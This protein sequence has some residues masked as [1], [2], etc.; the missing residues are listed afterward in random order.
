MDLTEE[1]LL[2]GITCSHCP[3]TRPAHESAFGVRVDPC[4]CGAAGYI[5]GELPEPVDVRLENL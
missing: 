4:E 3:R 2:N 1:I 5:L